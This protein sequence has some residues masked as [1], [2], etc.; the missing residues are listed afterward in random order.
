MWNGDTPRTYTRYERTAGGSAVAV[1]LASTA[2][3][4]S[5]AAGKGASIIAKTQ[6][7]IR[8]D[9]YGFVGNGVTDDLAA[10]QAAIV[11]AGVQGI[12]KIIVPYGAT[13]VSVVSGSIV[14]GPLA[15]GLVFEAEVPVRTDGAAGCILRYT[16]AGVCWDITFPGTANAS[17]GRWR[18]RGLGFKTT[19]GAAT[20]F[21]FNSV[22]NGTRAVGDFDGYAYIEHVRFEGCF[23]SGPDLQSAAQTGDFLR[24]A[25]MFQ[26]V[27][28]ENCFVRDY[29]HGIWLYGCDNCD[30][31]VRGFLCGIE[32]KV[33]HP[34]VEGVSA[35]LGND[36]SISPRFL[37]GAP[38]ASSLPA[39]Y[40]IWDGCKSTTIHHSL[41]EDNSLENPSATHRTAFLYLNG[42][43]TTLIKPHFGGG[44]SFHLG[45]FAR[46][47]LML[48]PFA[49]A[50]A[51][52]GSEPVIDAPVSWDFAGAQTGHQITVVGANVNIRDLFGT[53]P[54][55]QY[56]G[57]INVR[58]G[59]GVL[60]QNQPMAHSVAGYAPKQIMARPLGDGSVQ[61]SL[62]NGAIYKQV[63]G[64]WVIEFPS[65][66]QGQAF[67]DLK[68]GDEL[69]P[70]IYRFSFRR[71]AADTATYA[72]QV[73]LNGA[74]VV[75]AGGL[76]SDGVWRE[77]SYKADLSAAV[78]G[79]TVQVIFG[80]VAGSPNGTAHIEFAA[81]ERVSAFIADPTDPATTQAAVISILDILQAQG[82]MA[83]S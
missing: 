6:R 45:P 50:P 21:D 30:I 18:W 73:R 66:A 24:G 14:S 8:L 74:P 70:G 48:H 10:W 69:L 32:V 64:R 25:K 68:V 11:A 67:F 58:S 40:N 26:L 1:S 49:A 75:S 39:M 20:M 82:L 44:H 4:A 5:P 57:N 2:V 47:I 54:R 43:G 13:G 72:M 61:W 41:Y 46:N 55:I 27:V 42:A 80:P 7:A 28:D 56:V 34:P 63:D 3:L 12:S 33:E 77:H 79:D 16:G 29:R 78:A 38:V 35:P 59:D 23:A 76:A 60:N 52:A 37:G 62:A 83:P 53:N 9:D 81:L 19:Q 36:N 51:L 31:R 17:V 22:G 15:S 65:A 71:K